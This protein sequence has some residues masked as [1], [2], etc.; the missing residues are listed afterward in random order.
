MPVIT[1]CPDCSRK[2]RV[3]DELLGKKV[4][5]PGCKVVFT[6]AADSA[7]APAP[8]AAPPAPRQA[9]PPPPRPA[10]PPPAPRK[11]APPPEERPDE[12]FEEQPRSRRAPPPE[13]FADAPRGENEPL[14]QFTE[15]EDEELPR[16]RRLHEDD[17]YGEEGPDFSGNRAAWR[18]VATGIAIK[19]IYICIFFGLILCSGVAGG[20]IGGVSAANAAAA[21]GPRGG[22]NPAAVMATAGT[23]FF[24]LSAVMTLFQAAAKGLEVY[25]HYLGMAV[26]DKPGTGLRALAL[27]TFGLF[28]A[29]AGIT[30]PC[31]FLG[32]AFGAAGGSMFANPMAGTGA[33]LAINLLNLVGGLC[34]LVGSIIF[35]L[36]LRAV[37]IAVKRKDLGKQMWAFLITA[38]SVFLVGVLLAGVAIFV[39]GATAFSSFGGGGQPS[40][41]AASAMAGGMIGLLGLACLGGIVA[42]GLAIW[43]IIL[44]VQTRAAVA[45][46]AHRA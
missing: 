23:G 44:L 3:P 9:A 32:L 6:A 41:G 18:K 29:S 22:P 14:K 36:Y 45:N 31:N 21:R 15:E 7:G 19:I 39:V 16:G 20:V 40:P 24:I 33:L 10:A 34:W 17:E 37:A 4:R 30:V 27:T 13:Q 11:S 42:L 25:G 26:P 43:Y 2:L 8:P 38:V 28:A 12:R 35:I 1:S 5:C 46:F